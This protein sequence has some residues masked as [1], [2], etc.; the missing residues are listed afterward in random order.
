MKILIID[1]NTSITSSLERYLTIKGH[2]VK[3]CNQGSEG[4][5]LITS[6][7]WDAVLLDLSMPECSG[8][9]IIEDLEK[10]N[11]LMEN[12]IFLITA[13]A[14]PDHVLDSLTKKAGIKAYFRK[15]TQLST[16]LETITA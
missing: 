10:E 13:S 6:D 7:F 8:F 5:E 11:L 9:Q 15:P 12:R 2:Q 4:L 14:V 1:D 16:I 3:T